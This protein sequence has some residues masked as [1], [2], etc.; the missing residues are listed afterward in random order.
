MPGFKETPLTLEDLVKASGDVGEEDT[1]PEGS[2]KPE[3][4]VPHPY[5]DSS[6]GK[7]SSATLKALGAGKTLKPGSGQ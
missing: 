2:S 6:Y 7:G 1:A 5:G 4:N 3:P